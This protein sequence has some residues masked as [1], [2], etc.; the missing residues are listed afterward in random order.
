MIRRGMGEDFFYAVCR[1]TDGT[2]DCP[3][4]FLYREIDGVS[5]SLHVETLRE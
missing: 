1:V 2:S 3:R 5:R 4:F